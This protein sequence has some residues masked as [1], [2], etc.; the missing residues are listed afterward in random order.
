[1]SD[2]LPYTSGVG[3]PDERNANE[4]TAA[5]MAQRIEKALEKENTDPTARMN[6]NSRKTSK[7]TVVVE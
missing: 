3:S 7:R 6:E 5:N 1:M 2:I 4:R